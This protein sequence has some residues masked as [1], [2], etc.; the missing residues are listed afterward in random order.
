MRCAD[1]LGCAQLI[2]STDILEGIEFANCLFLTE[3]FQ[4]R[5]GLSQLQDETLDL[6]PA[7]TQYRAERG[8]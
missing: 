7:E 4:V 3:L 8:R 5:S 2:T 6:G 1:E